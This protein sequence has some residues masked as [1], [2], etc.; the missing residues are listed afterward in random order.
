LR[1]FASE[2]FS[3]PPWFHKDVTITI[4]QNFTLQFPIAQDDSG[5]DAG[6]YVN[7]SDVELPDIGIRSA[8]IISSYLE[9]SKVIQM[10]S[11]IAVCKVKILDPPLEV[12][13]VIQGLQKKEPLVGRFMIQDA[14]NRAYSGYLAQSSMEYPNGKITNIQPPPTW[15]EILSRF[16]SSEFGK[17]MKIKVQKKSEEAAAKYKNKQYA[18]ALALFRWVSV[19]SFFTHTQEEQY[20]VLRNLATGWEQY[21]KQEKEDLDIALFWAKEAKKIKSD[22]A[23]LSQI[24]RI[25]SYKK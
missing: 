9:G 7:E 1:S 19:W 13:T 16:Q 3:S 12:F 22:P 10:E 8:S 17:D 20:V 6:I 5:M 24:Q 18:Q 11:T 15:N 21:L 25:K 2:S 4:G 23:V 14:V